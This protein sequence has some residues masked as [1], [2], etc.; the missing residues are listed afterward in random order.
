MTVSHPRRLQSSATSLQKPH[1]SQTK[2]GS[3][4]QPHHGQAIRESLENFPISIIVVAIM[5]TG[6]DKHGSTSPVIPPA[7]CC[8]AEKH[9][10]QMSQGN[11]KIRFSGSPSTAGLVKPHQPLMKPQSALNFLA[12]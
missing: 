2:I 3:G 4:D 11:G 12:S 7:I 10:H 9:N 1:T 8:C 6:H 5:V